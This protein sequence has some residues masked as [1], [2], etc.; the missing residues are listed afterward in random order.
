MLAPDRLLAAARCS[1]PFANGEVVFIETTRPELIP[2]CV[3]LVAH[4]D[5]ERYQTLFG[6]TGAGGEPLGMLAG[7][8]VAVLLARLVAAIRSRPRIGEAALAI[9]A[10]GGLGDRVSSAL[11]LAVAFPASAGPVEEV[12]PAALTAVVTRPL[13][14]LVHALCTAPATP[15]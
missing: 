6:Q 8:A 3:A 7:A 2:A 5:D 15:G 9:D 13:S 1:S 4:P 12:D 10:E 11:E 14:A